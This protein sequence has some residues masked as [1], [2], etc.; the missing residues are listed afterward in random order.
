M[1]N[2]WDYDKKELE[3]TES[4]RI[5]ILERMLNYGPDKDQRIK[6]S[7]VKKY[8]NKLNLFSIRKR[9]LELLIWG[10]YK[11]SPRN[12]KAFWVK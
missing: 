9:L 10:K 2:L 12:S 5:L 1:S 3:K 6:L 4:G 11:T 8:W 7:E